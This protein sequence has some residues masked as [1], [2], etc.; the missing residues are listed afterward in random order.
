MTAVSFYTP[1]DESRFESSPLTAG[2]WGPDSQHAG[3]PSALLVR[4]MER[5]SPAPDSRLARVSVDVLGPVPV[6]PLEV[7][8]RVIRPGRSVEL[9]EATASVEGRAALVARGWR[10]RVTPGDFPVVGEQPGPDPALRPP[11]RGDLLPGA[12]AD[13]YLSVVDFHFVSGSGEGLG[14]ASAWGR[15]RADLVAGETMTGWQHL[16][17]VVDSA[18]GISMATHPF[19]HPAINCDLVVSL[20]RDPEPDWVYLDAETVGGPGGGVLTDTLLFDARGRLGRCVQ[21]LYGRRVSAGG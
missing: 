20:I 12:H 4:A 18:S 11:R 13:G 14:P 6:A 17:T 7:D 16:M 9:L 21:N 8:V 19:E 10:M 3:P 2:P 1:L 5:H 15:S